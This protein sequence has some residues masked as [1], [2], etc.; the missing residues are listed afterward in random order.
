MA[1]KGLGQ[2][3]LG[4]QPCHYGYSN[5]T[6]RGPEADLSAPYIAF[7]GGTE[8]VGPFLTHPFPTLVA[9]ACGLECVNLGIKNAGPDVFL[10]D[11]EVI[12]LVQGAQAVV[13]EV[14]GVRNLSNAYYE[15]HPRRN[16]R[17]T[18]PHA[19]LRDLMPTFDFVDVHYTGHLLEEIAEKAGPNACE[20]V[21]AELKTVWV[22]RMQALMKA[23]HAPV[24]LLRFVTR[25]AGDRRIDHIDPLMMATLTFH[26]ASV[27]RVE[28]SETAQQYGTAE[29]IFAPDEAKQARYMLSAAAHREAAAEV[30]RAV[31]TQIENARAS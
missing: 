17:V 27:T 30:A 12:K 14:T 16:D 24:H 18:R 2:T 29:M 3:L 7:L 1:D 11:P 28:P 22:D 31:I 26:A 21:V 10:K 13:L 8:T 19:A 4:L 15:V 20:R 5:L 25:I 6:F 9:E 23:I